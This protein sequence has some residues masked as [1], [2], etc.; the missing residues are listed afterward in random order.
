MNNITHFQ[1]RV[2]LGIDPGLNI[3]GFA[4]LSGQANRYAI[5]ECGYIAYDKTKSIQKKIKEFYD[6][7]HKQIDLYP[8]NEIAIETPFLGKNSAS[9]LKLGYLRSIIYLTCEQ[10]GI[11]LHEFA[12]RTIKQAITGYG[13]AEKQQVQQAISILFPQIAPLDIKKYDITD[14]I[15][16]ALCG[17][18]NRK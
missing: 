9:F 5:N 15:S 16:I 2:I 6:F 17:F 10:R 18:W 8:I 1:K 4:L 3:C 7:L 14:A 11:I 12:P 13:N